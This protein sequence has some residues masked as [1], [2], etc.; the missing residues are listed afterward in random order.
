MTDYVDIINPLAEMVKRV[1]PSLT[2]N[3]IEIGALP[4]SEK[5][6]RFHSLLSLFPGSKISAFELNEEQCVKWNKEAPE[7]LKY[8][9][10]ALGEKKEQRNL[11]E[12]RSP[13]CTSLYKPNVPLLSVFNRLEVV[14]LK[15]ESYVQTISLD[16]FVQANKI[17][18]ID[19]IKIDV[20]GA[21]YDIFKGAASVLKSTV[22]VVSEVEFVPLYEGQPLFGDVTEILSKNDL[23]FHKF[24]ALNGRPIK[25]VKINGN[26]RHPSQHLWS[27]AIYLSDLS[28]SEKHSSSDWAK[29]AIFSFLYG[30]SDVTYFCLKQLDNVH[31]SA[32]AS[33]FIARVASLELE[34]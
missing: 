33:D 8:Y 27:D 19:F 14:A 4:M 25:Q 12:T 26:P 18:S 20:Q 9:P 32:L 2:F 24:L 6:E 34:S 3:M 30:S 17:G 29:C 23:M 31:G 15:S 21:E 28:V 5:V 22:F 11:Y 13:M 1:E 7:G 10:V 16:E